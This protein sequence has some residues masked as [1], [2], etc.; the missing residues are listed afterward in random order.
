MATSAFGSPIAIIQCT[1]SRPQTQALIGIHIVRAATRVRWFAE[2]QIFRIIIQLTTR[3]TMF[4][5]AQ[6]MECLLEKGW[7]MSI[8]QRG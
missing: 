8:L 3:A 4:H 2:D 5:C 6:K 1:K 7:L